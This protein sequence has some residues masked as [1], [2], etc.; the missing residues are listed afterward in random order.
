MQNQKH[1]L[2]D[3]EMSIYAVLILANYT[4]VFYSLDSYC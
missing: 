1:S 2:N 3:H 4:N